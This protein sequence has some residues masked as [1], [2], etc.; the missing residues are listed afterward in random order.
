MAG[1]FHDAG[2]RLYP[3]VAIFVL[4]FTVTAHAQQTPTYRLN[5]NLSFAEPQTHLFKVRLEIAL[6]TGKMPEEISLQMPRWSPGRYAVFDFAKNVQEFRA[7]SGAPP[8]QQEEPLVV[9]RADDQTWTVRTKGNERLTI[10]YKVFGNNLSGTFS[11]FNARHANYNGG[12][13]FVYL[14]GNKQNPVTLAID[15]PANWRIANGRMTNAAQREWRFPNY[16][17]LIDT[18][19]EIAPDW[20]MDDFTVD[21]R[22]YHVVVHSL[23]EESKA[24]R[25]SLV[26]KIEKIVRAETGL[27]GP[28][29][30]DNYTFLIH[31]ASDGR[32]GDGMEHLTS[33]QV[34]GPGTLT[35]ESAEEDALEA[36]AHE[37]FHV[38][39]VKRL[40]PVELG[41]WD[42]T[43]PLN[44]R[45]LWI[46]E[47]LTNYYGTMMMRRSG[48]WS[49]AQLWQAYAGTIT[50]L[51]N[52][53]GVHLMSA[54]DASVLA[55][56][57]DG[58]P[59]AQDTNLTNTSISYYPKGEIIGLV[60]DLLIRRET[61]GARSLDDVMRRMYDEFYVRSPNATYYLKGRG[62]TMEDFERVTSGVAGKDM[63][64][65]FA[66]YVIG[67]ETP[68]YED[69]FAVIG[70]RLVGETSALS[71]PEDLIGIT[72]AG[73]AAGNMPSV[74]RVRPASPAAD[75][76]IYRGD[77]I[78]SVAGQNVTGE[79]W[80]QAIGKFKTGDQVA[81]VIERGGRR[82][83][84][85]LTLK[86]TSIT[87]YR[88]EER[89]NASSSERA[90][91]A[92]IVSSK[93]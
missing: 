22:A 21:G 39:N 7:A 9:T 16:D 84:T 92:R 74:R 31:F 54:V 49:D 30:F 82:I 24:R 91:R 60:L 28:P 43:R 67:V 75:A 52:S 37:F 85:T 32:S 66:R 40:R 64:E 5:Y 63:H 47:G 17:V 73:A 93:Q 65:F 41:P 70:L 62:Y 35:D 13:I 89:P 18:P 56:F 81:L 42:F 27:W 50:A 46:A 44:T 45:S 11:Q 76:G 77:Q 10:S 86:S 59:Q 53:P 69:A 29:D 12:S 55:P 36:V 79:S 48:L 15:P 61:N 25:S 33:T 23:G 80:P 1:R 83:N 90:E 68:P 6:L 4:F 8:Q 19:T 88:L 87:R 26:A 78:V 58:A 14:A 72:I 57:L 2:A 51:E 3:L 34:I 71:A 38:W 20:T